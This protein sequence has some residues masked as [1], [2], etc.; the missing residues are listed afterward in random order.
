MKDKKEECTKL[1][2][3]ILKNIEMSE[4]PFK[5][6]ILKGLRLCRLMNDE[7]GIKL[8][9]FEST[10]YPLG[11]NG[12]LTSEAWQLCDLSGR[13]HYDKNDKGKYE[14][15][16]FT[17]TIAEMESTN[18]IQ[19]ERMKVATDP[20]S[21]GDNATI[22]A[23]SIAKNTVERKNIIVSVRDNTKRIEIIKLKLY[24]YVLKIYNELLYGNIVE[25]IFR[26]NRNMVENKLKEHCP[27]TIK[28]LSSVYD[29]LSSSNS[30]D[31]ANAIHT[32]RR[33]LKELANTL[34]PP[35]NEIILAGRKE[36]KLGEEQY[37]NR[38]IQYINSKSKSKTY[39][40]IVGSSL[41]DIGNKLD[42][43][44]NAAC[45]GT[46]DNVTQFESN[47]YLIYT[48]LFLGDILSLEEPNQ[49]KEVI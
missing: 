40:E 11:E 10:G 12:K 19:L 39:K 3:E 14:E 4:I 2:D 6:V 35:T 41:E 9:T 5:S 48:Y 46:H 17:S 30:E 25:D 13:I 24:D 8:F 20:T 45:K 18:Q 23:I 43:L 34:Y 31:W 15:F 26:I 47:R 28:K 49:L 1:A 44:N 37:I 22:S 36:I 38:L 32:C 27:E 33:I 7:V 21:Y 42:A 29:N 16:A